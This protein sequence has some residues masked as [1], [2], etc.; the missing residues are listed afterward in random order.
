[1]LACGAFGSAAA[2]GIEQ[3]GIGTQLKLISSGF[4]D[5]VQSA[6][7]AP[8]FYTVTD[9]DH[10]GLLELFGLFPSERRIGNCEGL[11]DQSHWH[12]SH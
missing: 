9:L 11:G 4:H 6:D 7:S 5:Y 8:W 3:E 1:V 2:D 12:R 10:N